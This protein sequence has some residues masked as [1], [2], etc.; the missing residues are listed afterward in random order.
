MTTEKH[1]HKSIKVFGL[2]TPHTAAAAGQNGRPMAPLRQIFE[3]TAGADA[4]ALLA[5]PG[6]T[7]VVQLLRDAGETLCVED[8]EQLYAAESWETDRSFTWLELQALQHKIQKTA[9]NADLVD[10]TANAVESAHQHLHP[11]PAEDS[12]RA[13]VNG[14]PA[15]PRVRAVAEKESPQELLP[16]CPVDVG[17][18][19]VEEQ[20][21]R[22]TLLGRAIP[23]DLAFA[24]SLIAIEYDQFLQDMT[25]E[26]RSCL[27]CSPPE[28][29]RAK[30]YFPNLE[31]AVWQREDDEQTEHNISNLPVHPQE[32]GVDP[33]EKERRV[34]WIQ[35]LTAEREVCGLRPDVCAGGILGGSA[36]GRSRHLHVPPHL[37]DGSC[38][39]LRGIRPTYCTG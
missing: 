2:A 39:L 24:E 35:K 19:N 10:T 20:A 21:S 36:H 33:A 16:A 31:I 12:V 6:L 32:G 25:A 15:L 5:T 8:L 28:A 27:P 30:R 37:H 17:G 23:A 18:A 3:M 34:A 11:G 4:D 26:Q 9:V 13:D 29:F 1:V 38:S 22:R 14:E 7:Y